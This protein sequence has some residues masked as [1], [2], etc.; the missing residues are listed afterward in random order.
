MTL[1]A[2]RKD[3]KTASAVIHQLQIVGE[4]LNGV[5]TEFQAAHPDVPWRD[6]IAM[7][8]HLIHSY[9]RTDLAIVWRTVAE[10]LAQLLPK[11]DRALAES[12]R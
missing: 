10:D 8:H 7:R 11:L 6:A 2:F 3:E 1:D 4:A 12:T 9:F 5:S